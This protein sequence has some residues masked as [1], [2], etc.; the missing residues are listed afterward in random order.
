VWR[1]DAH[2]I[3]GELVRR[4]VLLHTYPGDT[5]YDPFCGSGMT[6][7]V[8]HQLGRVAWG[9]DTWPLAVSLSQQRLAA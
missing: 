4:L 1:R 7:Y 8:A 2:Q 9:S 3:P 5:V 6:P